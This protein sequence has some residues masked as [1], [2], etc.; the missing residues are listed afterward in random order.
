[1]ENVMPAPE[2]QNRDLTLPPDTYLYL[3]NE[4]KGGAITVH[5]GP[6]LVNQTGQDRP[7]RY[8]PNKRQYLACSL[9][10]ASTTIPS[11]GGRRLRH[12][13]KSFGRRESFRPKRT[14]QVSHFAKVAEIVIPG[15]WSEA[16]YPGQ[17]AMLLKV[18]DC[19]AIST[20]SPSSTTIKK[21][22]ANW[23][24]TVAKVQTDLLPKLDAQGNPI[25][26]DSAHQQTIKAKDLP[27]PTDFAVGTRIVIQG[28]DVSF[29]I[30]CTGVEVMVE[31][32]KYV[33]DAVTLEQ[34]EYCCLIDE[35]GKKTYPKGP[36]VVFP[37]PTQVFEQD[38]KKRR[39]FTPI[40][41]NTINGIHLK[42]T[43]D[44]KGPDLEKRSSDEREYKEGEEL[45]VTG[46]T[47]SIY[48]PR[49]ELAIIEYGC[50]QQEALLNGDP[51]GRSPLCDNRPSKRRDPY[52][53]RPENVSRRSSS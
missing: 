5:R 40:E 11:G 22:E 50:R 30:P 53:E 6:A 23:D 14:T 41:L 15:P 2:T 52:G 20:L 47:M 26:P 38:S 45:F 3:Q 35:N 49:E 18:T 7:V 24:K 44:F 37:S 16:L 32:G 25:P 27:K 29:Y 48:Y 17:N 42:V 34:L 9:E 28:I 13:R 51:E 46:R 8:D 43:A 21:L 10:Q 19:G 12:S 36:A 31:D 39:K 1:M 33:R 4:A